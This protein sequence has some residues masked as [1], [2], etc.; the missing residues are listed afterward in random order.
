MALPSARAAPLAIEILERT[1]R[2]P[3]R[4]TADAWLLE[5]GHPERHGDWVLEIDGRV[6]DHGRGFDRAGT[7]ANASTSRRESLCRGFL[8][9]LFRRLFRPLRVVSGDCQRYALYPVYLSAVRL[10]CLAVP[11]AAGKRARHRHCRTP[12]PVRAVFPRDSDR[13]GPDRRYL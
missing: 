2:R 12:A 8:R 13:S 9:P 7:S 11:D 6:C 10:R 5:P 4:A 1:L 3:D